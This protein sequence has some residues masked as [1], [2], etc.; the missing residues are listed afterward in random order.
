VSKL[1]VIFLIIIGL[2]SCRFYKKINHY[3]GEV[4]YGNACGI[5]GIE[6]KYRAEAIELIQLRDTSTLNS[7]LESD[8]LVINLYAAEALLNL[9]NGGIQIN[10]VQRDHIDK[11]KR[12]RT[13][14]SVCS[15]CSVYNERVKDIFEKKN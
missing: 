6:P 5:A 7:W 14:I 8:D 1:F 15:G 11:L 3:K 9:E 10:K 13:F 2:A 12:N 4:V